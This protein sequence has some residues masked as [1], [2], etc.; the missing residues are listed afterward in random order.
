MVAASA[1]PSITVTG[2]PRPTRFTTSSA[3]SRAGQRFQLAPAPGW[4]T[5]GDDAAETLGF[6][7]SEARGGFRRWRNGSGN[8]PRRSEGRE[9][10]SQVEAWHPGGGYGEAW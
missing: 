2:R 3:Y 6:D 10:R 4:M 8:A 9:S 7:G 1:G 5:T